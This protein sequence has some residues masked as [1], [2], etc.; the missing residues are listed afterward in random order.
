M[1]VGFSGVGS[2]PGADMAATIRLTLGEA[3]TSRYEIV[4]GDS[5]AVAKKPCG[6]ANAASR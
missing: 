5:A 4:I 3:A 2:W 1:N 6:C